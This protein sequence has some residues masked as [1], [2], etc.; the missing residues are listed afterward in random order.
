[1]SPKCLFFIS[2]VQNGIKCEYML[3]FLSLSTVDA[4]E[5]VPREFPHCKKKVKQK[6]STL[7]IGRLVSILTIFE[8]LNRILVIKILCVLWK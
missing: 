1:M 8:R 5:K 4:V 2:F 3:Q 7:G 6:C